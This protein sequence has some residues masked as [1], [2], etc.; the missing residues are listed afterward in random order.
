MKPVWIGQTHQY[1]ADEAFFQVSKIA[2]TRSGMDEFR[3]FQLWHMMGEATK[4]PAGL[5][6]EVGCGNGGSGFLVAVRARLAR[7]DCPVY[8]FDTFAGLVKAGAADMLKDGDMAGPERDEVQSFIEG[9]GL[10]GV[11]ARRGIFP[12]DFWDIAG[13]S[14]R[15][16]HIDVDIYQ[17][18]KDAFEAIWPRMVPGGIVVLDDYG[19]ANCPGVTKFVDESLPLLDGIWFLHGALQAIVVKRG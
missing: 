17:S 16:A 13:S 19:E 7:L 5:V 12:E 4:L 9:H 2:A 10:E 15:F 11:H 1:H 8:L 6:I 18:M 14:F 3:M